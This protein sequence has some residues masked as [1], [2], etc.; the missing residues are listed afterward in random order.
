ML[1]KLFVVLLSYLL[2]A[3]LTARIFEISSTWLKAG[4]LASQLLNPF[5]LSVRK[6]KAILEQRGVSYK[7]LVE[8]KELAELV[9]ACGVVT[10]AEN[11]SVVTE[12]S[13]DDKEESD[14]LQFT[15]ASHFFEEVEDT[16]AGTWLVDVIPQ[17][18]AS[19]LRRK[20]WVALKRK[21]SR[22]G[23]R[24]GTFNCENDLRLCIKYGWHEPS[25]VI[26]MPQGN[27]PKGNV[28]LKTYDSK[29]SVEL[30]FKWINTQL[31]SKIAMFDSVEEFTDTFKASLKENPVY[32]VLFSTLPDPPLYLGSLSV[33]FTGRV[34]FGH[35]RINDWTAKRHIF[36]KYNIDNFPSLMIFTPE[37]NLTY[38]HRKGEWITYRP[39]ELFLRTIHPE[40]NDVF[41]TVLL[42]VN[43]SCFMGL[44]LMNGGILKRMI[45]FVWLLIFYNTSLI[46]LCL[47]VLT[48]LQLPFLTPVLDLTLK[49]C[50][51][52]MTSDVAAIMRDYICLGLQ[53]WG[54]VFGGYV[55][56]GM[57]IRW[58]Q[59]RI[60][61]YFGLE[62]ENDNVTSISEWFAQ[63][64]YYLTNAVQTFP[65]LGQPRVDYSASGLEDGFELLVRRLAVP[66]LWLRPIIPTEYI[67]SLPVWKF[68]CSQ[69][70]Q[71]CD[72][73]QEHCTKKH[74][75]HSG[76]CQ[77]SPKPAG[78]LV[79]HDCAICLEDF[80]KGCLLLGLP[81]GH[82]YHQKC[83]EVWLC[84]GHTSGHYCCPVCRWPAYKRKPLALEANLPRDQSQETSY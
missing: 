14:E 75:K 16:K 51:Y 46:I 76:C 66:E 67:N 24:I 72:T 71:C 45:H 74:G 43:M 69:V 78:M 30:V 60:N 80:K 40:V 3:F 59:M 81:C 26:S 36:K 33:H 64:L 27:Q 34:R 31:S 19:L 32:V 56:Y 4:C 11:C 7:G 8:K 37:G 61:S 23:I 52:A 49:Y 22:F 9:E 84:G 70:N 58:I 25:L 17:G 55:I 12:N 48:L 15:G 65:S 35:V 28:I 57:L 38:G 83:I 79:A 13:R 62:S 68:C 63:D 44:F 42:V 5:A 77:E 53:H 2:L 39:L 10:E 20:Q 54:L 29:S 21:I 47:P 50:R 18:H 41:V 82:C 1:A 6:L 73:K